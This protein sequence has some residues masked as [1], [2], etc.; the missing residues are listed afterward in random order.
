MDGEHGELTFHPVKYCCVCWELRGDI[1]KE[2]RPVRSLTSD[3]RHS[4]LEAY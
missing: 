1:G 3:S 2:N 4:L